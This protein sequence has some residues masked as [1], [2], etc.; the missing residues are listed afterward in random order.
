MLNQIN[1]CM[2]VCKNNILVSLGGLSSDTVPCNTSG[3]V[4]ICIIWNRCNGDT[5][6]LICMCSYAWQCVP[7]SQRADRLVTLHYFVL[8]WLIARGDLIMLK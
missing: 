1:K 8:T 3:T 5:D 7:C 6:H 2:I 4:L